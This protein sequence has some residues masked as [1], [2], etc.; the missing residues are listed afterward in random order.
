MWISYLLLFLI[1]LM[2]FSAVLAV[3]CQSYG[4][5]PDTL[6]IKSRYPLLALS[7][8]VSSYFSITIINQLMIDSAGLPSVL[9]AALPWMIN[10]AIIA[11]AIYL[12]NKEI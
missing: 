3:Y 12:I 4:K 11:A 1:P 7:C 10:T 5:S 9:F 6:L 2:T 8:L